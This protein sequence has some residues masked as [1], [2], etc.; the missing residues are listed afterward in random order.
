MSAAKQ[1]IALAPEYADGYL[2]LGLL[3]IELKQ[4]D[5]ALKNLEKAKELGDTRAEGYIKKMK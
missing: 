1:C 3:Q 4:K 5:E 2:L